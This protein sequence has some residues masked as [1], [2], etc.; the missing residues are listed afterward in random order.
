MNIKTVFIVMIRAGEK[1]V[2]RHHRAMGIDYVVTVIPAI[3][4]KIVFVLHIPTILSR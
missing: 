1:K 4:Q 3:F 2:N